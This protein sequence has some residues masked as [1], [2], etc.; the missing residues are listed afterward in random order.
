THP[1]HDQTVR[2]Q[3]T[4]PVAP[5]NSLVRTR[6]RN[7]ESAAESLAQPPPC[8]FRSRQSARPWSHTR[9]PFSPVPARVVAPDY[10]PRSGWNLCP[11]LTLAIFACKPPAACRDGLAR[12][13]RW[14]RMEMRCDLLCAKERQSCSQ[15]CRRLYSLSSILSCCCAGLCGQFHSAPTPKG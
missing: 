9:R 11:S 2:W 10:S 3:S 4:Q 1:S 14:R 5:R 8:P 6:D 7:V 12:T 15:S 13:R